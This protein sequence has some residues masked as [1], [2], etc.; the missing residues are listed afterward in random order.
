MSHSHGCSLSTFHFSFI[1]YEQY[2]SSSSLSTRLNLWNQV[3]SQKYI[4]VHYCN[5]FV[6]QV[7]SYSF[8]HGQ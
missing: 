4:S 8:Y 5:E 7:H 1:L 3:F 2:C 6:H